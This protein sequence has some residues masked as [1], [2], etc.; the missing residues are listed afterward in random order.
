MPNGL[1][2]LLRLLR[3]S[4]LPYR[5]RLR[6]N[7]L[8]LHRIHNASQLRRDGRGAADWRRDYYCLWHL[9]DWVV[10]LRAY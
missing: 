3:R 8:S 5:P 1:L 2:R 7:R 9:R 10:Q 6:D 4:L